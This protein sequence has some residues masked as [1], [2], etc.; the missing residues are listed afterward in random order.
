MLKSSTLRGR[1]LFQHALTEC[2]AQADRLQVYLSWMSAAQAGLGAS[3]AP[4]K[5][6]ELHNEL[7]FA[8]ELALAEFPDNGCA[9]SPR[10]VHT[11]AG[12]PRSRNTAD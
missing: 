1:E 10:T 4:D 8:A 2:A 3:A 9:L 12:W 5:A 7:A 11:A 6:S